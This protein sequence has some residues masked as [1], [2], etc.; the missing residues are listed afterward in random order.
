MYA[1]MMIFII[2]INGDV[3]FHLFSS[4]WNNWEGVY[5]VCTPIKMVYSH[6]SFENIQPK[7]SS[8]NIIRCFNKLQLL[9]RKAS[10][11]W[12]IQIPI[13]NCVHK[14]S[15]QYYR[16]NVSSCFNQMEYC[17]SGGDWFIP[18]TND[19]GWI[20]VLFNKTKQTCT[21]FQSITSVR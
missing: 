10:I 17:D 15:V 5:V 19:M 7:Y 14:M 1:C 13:G 6:Y 9:Y 2:I 4:I 11:N 12:E 20:F 18:C 21:S 16:G 8:S 3:N